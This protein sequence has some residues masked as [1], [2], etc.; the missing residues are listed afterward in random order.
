[1]TENEKKRLAQNGSVKSESKVT[2]TPSSKTATGSSTNSPEIKRPLRYER[3]RQPN[4]R[5]KTVVKGNTWTGKSY[6]DVS[7]AEYKAFAKKNNAPKEIMDRLEYETTLPGSQFYNPYRSGTQHQEIKDFFAENY[8][9][10]GEF[11]DDFVINYRHF[12]NGVT[13]DMRSTTTGSL[14]SPGKKGT[15][16]QWAAYYYNQIARYNKESNETNAQWSDMR[17]AYANFYR[18]FETVYQRK[19]TMEEFVNAVDINDYS[20]LKA[21]EDSYTGEKSLQVLNVGTNYSRDAITGLYHALQNGE[22]ISVDRDYVEDAVEYYMNPVLHAPSV[23]GKYDWSNSDLSVMSDEDAQGYLQG[24]AREGKMEEYAAF[25]EALWQSR[26]H[27]DSVD[28]TNILGETYG[29]YQNDEW[30][31]AARAAL[32]DEYTMRLQRDGSMKKPGSNASIVDLACYELW[33]AEQ[34]RE[35]TDEV[36]A[37]MKSVVDFISERD[38]SEYGSEEESSFIDEALAAIKGSDFYAPIEKYI[39]ESEKNN[40]Y[41]DLTCRPVFASEANIIEMLKMRWKGETS[42][43]SSVDYSAEFFAGTEEM[44]A[45]ETPSSEPPAYYDIQRMENAAN[46][47][48]ERRSNKQIFSSVIQQLSESGA[49]ISLTDFEA[50]AII[51]QTYSSVEGMSGIVE[52]L[53]YSVAKPRLDARLGADASYDQILASDPVLKGL[54]AVSGITAIPELTLNDIAQVARLTMQ[55]DISN[56]DPSLAMGIIENT[57]P[58]INGILNTVNGMYEKYGLVRTQDLFNGAFDAAAYRSAYADAKAKGLSEEEAA[59]SA[60]FKAT[61][62]VSAMN[63]VGSKYEGSANVS[64]AASELVNGVRLEEGTN[65]VVDILEIVNDEVLAS[66]KLGLDV[67]SDGAPD[68][69]AFNAAIMI[70][71]TSYAD[72]GFSAFT[73]DIVHD[74][75]TGD[76]KAEHVA[77]GVKAYN[78]SLKLASPLQMAEANLVQNTPEEYIA[79]QKAAQ[80][81]ESRMVRSAEGVAMSAQDYTAAKE[82]ARNYMSGFVSPEEMSDNLKKAISYDHLMAYLDEV[83]ANDIPVDRM[84]VLDATIASF[85]SENKTRH[86]TSELMHG[87]T[88]INAAIAEYASQKTDA[89]RQA[90]ITAT[91]RNYLQAMIEDDRTNFLPRIAAVAGYLSSDTGHFVDAFDN[92]GMFFSNEEVTAIAESYFNGDVTLKEVYAIIDDRKENYDVAYVNALNNPAAVQDSYAVIDAGMENL[93]AGFEANEADATSDVIA[94][95]RNGG[96]IHDAIRDYPESM[97]GIA[98]NLDTYTAQAEDEYGGTDQTALMNLV[99]SELEGNGGAN[100]TTEEQMSMAQK[101]VDF[102]K[103]LGPAGYLASYMTNEQVKSYSNGEIDLSSVGIASLKSILDRATDGAWTKPYGNYEELNLAH[104]VFGGTSKFVGNIIASPANMLEVV[105]HGMDAVTGGWYTENVASLPGPARLAMRQSEASAEIDSSEAEYA[106]NVLTSTDIFLREGISEFL[107]N[108]FISGVGRGLAGVVGKG[109]PVSDLT[110]THMVDDAIAG[111]ADIDKAI[112]MSTTIARRLPFAANVFANDTLDNYKKSKSFS[113]SFVKGVLSAGI[114]L[115]TEAMPLE[116]MLSFNVRGAKLTARAMNAVNSNSVVMLGWLSNTAK[117]IATEIGE[118]ELSMLLGRMVDFGDAAFAQDK[119]VGDAFK[120]SFSGMGE[121]AKATALSTAFTTLM[122]GAVDLGGMTYQNARRHMENGTE[123][124]SEQLL[125]DMLTDI[126]LSMDEDVDVE[127]A[128]ENEPEPESKPVAEVESAAEAEPVADAEAVEEEVAQEESEE[129]AS[130]PED[131]VA[132]AVKNQILNPS[133]ENVEAVVAAVEAL[134]T[135]PTEAEEAAPVEENPDTEEVEA[136]AEESVSEAPVA[137]ES[138][139][140][141]EVVGPELSPEGQKVNNYLQQSD[142]EIDKSIV[143]AGVERAADAAIEADPGIKSLKEQ[144]AAVQAKIVSKDNKIKEKQ[145]EVDSAQNRLSAMARAAAEQGIDPQTNSD[146]NVVN[147]RNQL[148]QGIAAV[149]SEIS[150]LEEERSV[151]NNEFDA[152]QKKIKEESDRIRKETSDKTRSDI[153]KEIYEFKAQTDREKSQYDSAQKDRSGNYRSQ[154]FTTEGEYSNYKAKAKGANDAMI[155]LYSKGEITTEEYTDPGY[156]SLEK[157]ESSEVKMPWEWWDKDV[158]IPYR[159]TLEDAYG[160]KVQSSSDVYNKAYPSSPFRNDDTWQDEQKAS[161]EERQIAEEREARM[162]MKEFADSE[163]LRNPDDA[164]EG[165]TGFMI[166]QPRKVYEKVC[167]NMEADLGYIDQDHVQLRGGYQDEFE[168]NMLGLRYNEKD[169]IIVPKG[170][171]LSAVVDKGKTDTGLLFDHVTENNKYL[172]VKEHHNT[173]SRTKAQQEYDEAAGFYGKD[174]EGKT[175]KDRIYAQYT[176]LQSKY[177]N[178]QRKHKEALANLE[179][180]KAALDKVNEENA[181]AKKIKGAAENYQKAFDLVERWQRLIDQCISEGKLAKEQADKRFAQA[182]KKIKELEAAIPPGPQKGFKQTYLVINKDQLKQ[183]AKDKIE[184]EASRKAGQEIE[185]CENLTRD[186]WIAKCVI[187]NALSAASDNEELGVDVVQALQDY[188]SNMSTDDIAI[189]YYKDVYDKAYAEAAKK[190]LAGAIQVISGL[191]ELNAFVRE[192][193]GYE[194]DYSDSGL[195]DDL[196]NG[197]VFTD[198]RIGN[199]RYMISEFALRMYGEDAIDKTEQGKKSNAQFNKETSQKV[200]EY[201]EEKGLSREQRERLRELTMVYD[202]TANKKGKVPFRTVDRGAGNSPF[203]LQ[204]R[205]VD[206]NNPTSNQYLRDN[207]LGDKYGDYSAKLAWDRMCD[208]MNAMLKGFDKYGNI[209]PDRNSILIK[210]IDSTGKEN[211]LRYGDYYTDKDGNG[212]RW[213]P[214]QEWICNNALSV[215]C[216]FFCVN[217]GDRKKLSAEDR[218]IQDASQVNFKL[219]PRTMAGGKVEIDGRY[220]NPQYDMNDTSDPTAYFRTK[221]DL[222][223]DLDMALQA[224][225]DNPDSPDPYILNA[226]IEA[227]ENR[228]LHRMRHIA[229]MYTSGSISDDDRAWWEEKY[230]EARD[231]LEKVRELTYE[232]KK[233]YTFMKKARD[234]SSRK[235]AGYAPK[236]KADNVQSREYERKPLEDLKEDK[237]YGSMGM[238]AEGGSL[239]RQGSMPTEKLLPRE[240]IGKTKSAESDRFAPHKMTPEQAYRTRQNAMAVYNQLSSEGDVYNLPYYDM[241]RR[242]ALSLIEHCD[243]VLAENPDFVPQEENDTEQPVQEAAAEVSPVDVDKEREKARDYYSDLIVLSSQAKNGG[244]V[245]EQR[246][247]LTAKYHEAKMAGMNRQERIDYLA[248][249]AEQARKNNDTATIDPNTDYDALLKKEVEKDVYN[250][251]DVSDAKKARRQFNSIAQKAGSYKRASAIDAAL[252]RLDGIEKTGVDPDRIAEVRKKL[253]ENREVL[254]SEEES[255]IAINLSLF[256]DTS[257]PFAN[258]TSYADLLQANKDRIAANKKANEE[259][260]A[261]RERE[262]A[263]R[264]IPWNRGPDVIPAEGASFNMDEDTGIGHGPINRDAYVDKIGMRNTMTPEQRA[265]DFGFNESNEVLPSAGQDA[266]YNAIEK[267]SQ[268]KVEVDELNGQI[269][270]LTDEITRTDDADKKAELLEQKATLVSDRNAKKADYNK[271]KNDRLDDENKTA[272]MEEVLEHS[273]TIHKSAI[274]TEKGRTAAHRIKNILKTLRRGNL[275]EGVMNV[276]SDAEFGTALEEVFGKDVLER[277]KNIAKSLK[278]DEHR[279]TRRA[280]ELRMEIAC[281]EAV[282]NGHYAYAMNESIPKTKAFKAAFDAYYKNRVNESESKTDGDNSIYT[283]CMEEVMGMLDKYTQFPEFDANGQKAVIHDMQEKLIDAE[284]RARASGIAS[285][286]MYRMSAGSLQDIINTA[287]GGRLPTQIADMVTMALYDMAGRQRSLKG[288]AVQLAYNFGVRNFVNPYAVVSAYCGEYAPVINKLFIEPVIKNNGRAQKKLNEY[289]KSIKKTKVNAKNSADFHRWAEGYLAEGMDDEEKS[290][291]GYISFKEYKAKHPNDYKTEADMAADLE[292]FRAIYD[293]TFG[294]MNEQ[295]EANGLDPVGFL[296]G[297]LPHTIDKGNS[298]QSFMSAVFDAGL[299][300]DIAG[301]TENFK[302]MHQWNPH[303]MHRSGTDTKFDM[304]G[305]FESYIAPVMNTIYHTGDIMRLRQLEQILSSMTK[306][307]MESGHSRSYY[308]DF[309]AWLM[310]YTN[311]L[312]G[313]KIGFGRVLENQSN[314]GIYAAADMIKQV[315]SDSLIAG[316]TKVALT[317]VLPIVQVAAHD[318]KNT[319]KA[320]A[321]LAMKYDITDG[322]PSPVDAMSRS[323]FLASR[324]SQSMISSSMY[325]EIVSKGYIPARLVDGYCSEVVWLTCYFNSLDKYGDVDTAIVRADRMALEMMGSKV[326]GEG[327][328]VFDD[329]VAGTLLQFTS[330]GFNLLNYYMN[331]MPKYNGGRPD[332]VLKNVIFAMLGYFLYNELFSSSSA[333][334]VIGSVYH[335][336]KDGDSALQIASRIGESINP[337]NRLMSE[338]VGSIPMISGFADL[339]SSAGEIVDAINDGTFDAM[340]V[341]DLGAAAMGFVPW[342]AQIN[343]TVGGV[344]SL[345]KGYNSYSGKIQYPVAINPWNAAIAPVLGVSS[346]VEGHAAKWG[347]IEA[348][349]PTQSEA[350]LKL[351]DVVGGHFSDVYN[352]I[353]EGSKAEEHEDVADDLRES[354]ASRTDVKAEEAKAAESRSNVEIPAAMAGIGED[355]LKHEAVQKGLDIWRE[356]GVDVFMKPELSFSTNNAVVDEKGNKIPGFKYDDVFTGLTDEEIRKLYREYRVNYKSIVGAFELTGDSPEARKASAEALKSKLESMTTNIKKKFAKSKGGE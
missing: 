336:I 129:S 203:A 180:A 50:E 133:E 88:D 333:P 247:A 338:G 146:P 198:R 348:L 39:N 154:A 118:E 212:K 207:I 186:E 206:R 250:G 117:S 115:G 303:M 61:S 11:D 205:S 356:T 29:Y 172:V 132:E 345:M 69:S 120:D 330:E 104:T 290:N 200:D 74:I 32:G 127:E 224:F 341:E 175:G 322:T 119:P 103:S 31:D 164:N 134:E 259:E 340:V 217:K 156:G 159:K 15:T 287:N 151:L 251:V 238:F 249:I 81:P 100:A 143:N 220:Y 77:E 187:E 123:Y 343:R 196:H 47:L 274:R 2:N 262:E 244:D 141:A 7:Y 111:I 24:L 216:N 155:D 41:V 286:V 260:Q 43:K 98:E 58:G 12:L 314:R 162:L 240:R 22:D 139:Q 44:F 255:G 339:I 158:D 99:I 298:F 317:N 299:P 324:L 137:P 296:K 269:K 131:E 328:I 16:E 305:N 167:K 176:E 75:A 320:L 96:T 40:G 226:Y 267:E 30:F 297:Y 165:Q 128:V 355:Q 332:R 4:S 76:I 293:E 92:N 153:A 304:L 33:Q 8:G 278:A 306:Q 94:Y 311:N 292:V 241:E 168:A 246:T 114:E 189:E 95:L 265:M 21:I 326:K 62:I 26:P 113:K 223:D 65:E 177:K 321:W 57:L 63:S 281:A 335:G 60:I 174:S 150:Q 309:N 242:M 221:Q 89:D 239:G 263:A 307:D 199:T 231:K 245:A 78:D 218:A 301:R 192:N 101:A 126:A 85:H 344:K 215:T 3:K 300:A 235:E 91:E 83:E 49:N 279:Y 257:D 211:S 149:Q 52:A 138:A 34:K 337:A 25:N 20:K 59:S 48:D 182:E 310:S 312:A 14:T 51:P 222:Q 195:P 93:T 73:K 87:A 152:V 308:Q 80:T 70:G 204:I 346:T 273:S 179:K 185:K 147:T 145:S 319:S 191:K 170:T 37:A 136:P 188:Y 254:K 302:P 157:E 107:R 84:A 181:S 38:T 67:D 253:E 268:M 13:D 232:K 79:A 283:Q 140:K 135:A 102:Y 142:A 71:S 272:A 291:L 17:N 124:S 110:Y 190:E 121:E 234:A 46:E 171:V 23:K 86:R 258:I 236:K 28:T 6:S 208:K 108:L 116:K 214:T 161:E 112:K 55:S 56:D 193:G 347:K 280:V 45:A 331:A 295:L 144:A 9:Y 289:I 148:V 264:D 210:F 288:K 256:G 163:F 233:T 225:R 277:N 109:M 105:R 68:M 227:Q 125:R 219:V 354:G 66:S 237:G 349:T 351:H 323:S 353:V 334:D 228:F 261:A 202:D 213:F 284:R 313:K 315:R 248:R 194:S 27:D 64:A 229:D 106:A 266:A 42:L 294:L 54:N 169:Q 318:A 197:L 72:P 350:A 183:T 271:A 352:Y 209:N 97:A 230:I 36:E 201:A 184:A 178:Y 5:P 53:W 19:P 329:K 90:N 122:F 1:M 342:G 35:F 270:E 173:P 285:K 10:T 282:L 325:R 276:Y 82:E 160:T 243:K 316:N 275:D 18:E 166:E 252:A 130:K 327:A